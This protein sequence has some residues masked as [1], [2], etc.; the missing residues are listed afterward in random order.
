MVEYKSGPGSISSST[1]KDQFIERDLFN[2][3]SLDQIQWR[4]EGITLI[5]EQLT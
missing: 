5:K 2:A 4:M 1:I 3:N